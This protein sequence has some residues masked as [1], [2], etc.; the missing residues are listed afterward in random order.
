MSARILI[1]LCLLGAGTAVSAQAPST[2]TPLEAELL[3]RLAARSLK[4]GD[5]VYARVLRDWTGPGCHLRPGATLQGAVRLATAHSHLSPSRLALDFLRAECHDT[6]L[7][8]YHLELAALAAPTQ[9]PP[10]IA[11]DLPT[12]SA[13]GIQTIS[14]RQSIETVNASLPLQPGETRGLKDLRLTIAAGPDRSSVISQKFYDV[15]IE[16]HT[17]LTLRPAHSDFPPPPAPSTPIQPGSDAA[18]AFLHTPPIK[19][20]PAD[21]EDTDVAPCTPTPCSSPNEAEP[22]LSGSIPLTDLGYASRLN[23]EIASPSYDEALAWLSPGQILVTFNPHKLV[24]RYASAAPDRTVRVIRAVLIDASSRKVLQAVDWRLSDRRQFLWHLP[25]YR[26]LVHEGGELRIYGAGLR[27]EQR[28]ALAGPL[29]FARVSPDGQIIAI[30]VVRERHTPTLHAS[31]ADSLQRDPDE[32]VVVVL[33]NGRFQTLGAAL[34]NS[35]APAPVLLNEGQAKIVVGPGQAKREHKQYA[36]ILRTWDNTP[37]TLSRFQSACTPEISSF[38][39]DLLFLV[40]CSKNNTRDYSVLRSDGRPLLRSSSYLRE[41]GHAASGAG[42]SA[43]FAVRIFKTGTPMIPGEPFHVSDLES[44]DLIIYRCDDG[45]RLSTVHVK[46]PAASSAGYAV[47]PGG[48]IAIL[49]RDDVD[50]YKVPRQ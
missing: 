13:T 16:P 45:K 50:V 3:T 49:T 1:V 47:S 12:P 41:M 25:G 24:P 4:Q 8:P 10:E 27:V 29:A 26:V 15:Q 7:E 18:V 40:T 19:F 22:A 32:D 43:T 14:L 38:P 9:Y 48:E 39:P 21:R 37:R 6:G 36:L 23:S 30:G 11:A 5:T 28:I 46:D 34:G 2:P 44:A 33:M 42:S 31:L 20:L 17:R 35:D